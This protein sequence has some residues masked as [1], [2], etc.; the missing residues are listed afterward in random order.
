MF[1]YHTRSRYGLNQR[2]DACN[3]QSIGCEQS[4]DPSHSWFLASR[5][6][7]APRDHPV[8]PAAPGLLNTLIAV[9]SVAMIKEELVIGIGLTPR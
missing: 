9:A 6:R 5:G 1:D 7:R 8:L 4:G 3:G 2:L